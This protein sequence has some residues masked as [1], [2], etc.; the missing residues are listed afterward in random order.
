MKLDAWIK[1]EG[2]TGSEFARRIERS[3]EFVYLLISGARGP[4]ARTIRRIGEVTDGQVGADDFD[5]PLPRKQ[6]EA[7]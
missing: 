3:P 5:D 2:I 6:V 7:A 1:K 4:S